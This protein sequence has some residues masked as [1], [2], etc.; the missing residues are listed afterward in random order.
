M[1]HEWSAGAAVQPG[2]SAASAAVAFYI[3]METLTHLDGDRAR[4]AQ[5]FDQAAR[6]A[7]VFDNIPRMP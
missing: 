5:L 6:V 2:L 4:P 1:G 3:G 7:A